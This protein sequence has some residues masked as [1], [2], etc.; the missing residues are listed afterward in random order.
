MYRMFVTV[1]VSALLATASG[2]QQRTRIVK[3]H[4]LDLVSVAGQKQ[5]S[6][7]LRRAVDYVCRLPNPASPLTGVEDQDCRAAVMAHVQ[8]EMQAAVELAQAR[9]ASQIAGR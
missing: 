5:L 2:A 7:R 1:A 4:D 9:A 3:Y 8:S 6:H